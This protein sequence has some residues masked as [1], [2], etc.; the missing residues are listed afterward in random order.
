MTWMAMLLGLFLPA[1]GAPGAQGLPTPPPGT[2]AA[3][4]R[5]ASPN[6]ALAAAADFKP[7]ADIVLPVYHLPPAQL[8]A[9][10]EAV[11]ASEPRVFVQIVYPAT[12]EAHW[13]ARSALLN[14]PDLIVAQVSPAGKDSSTLTLYSRSVYGSS[15]LG[16]NRK[17]LQAWIA[18]LNARLPPDNSR[19]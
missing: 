2:L 6:S 15:D 17:R 4:Q 13:V 16:V 18:A 8:F 1:C 12:L 10:I 11:A 14:F 5:P 9:A 19:S 3:L 7:T